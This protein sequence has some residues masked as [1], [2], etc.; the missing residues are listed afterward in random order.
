MSACQIKIPCFWYL[1]IVQNVSRYNHTRKE[2]FWIINFARFGSNKNY[3]LQLPNKSYPI[4]RYVKVFLFTLLLFD[5][6]GKKIWIMQFTK[7]CLIICFICKLFLFGE[8]FS[9]VLYFICVVKIEINVKKSFPFKG[10]ILNKISTFRI[11]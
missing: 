8:L 4:M 1:T 6:T 11:C 9:K 10:F 2:V 5:Q 3:T 7:F